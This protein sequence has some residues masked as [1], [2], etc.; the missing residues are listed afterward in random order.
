MKSRAEI[1]VIIAQFPHI[2]PV[3]FQ[4]PNN[5]LASF[6]HAAEHNGEPQKCYNEGLPCLPVPVLSPPAGPSPA[7]G[8]AQG[9][10][11]PFSSFWQLHKFLLPKKNAVLTF[12]SS[13][14]HFEEQE[15]YLC[16]LF[17][18]LSLEVIEERLWTLIKPPLMS[19]K[20]T[21][22]FL[23][24]CYSPL[25]WASWEPA[26][27][28]CNLNEGDQVY[29]VTAFLDLDDTRLTNLCSMLLWQRVENPQENSIAQPF[30]FAFV[31]EACV[32]CN[33]QHTHIYLEVRQHCLHLTAWRNHGWGFRKSAR[34]ICSFYRRFQVFG[35]T[36]SFSQGLGNSLWETVFCIMEGKGLLVC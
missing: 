3:Q 10:R 22:I 12:L 11:T 27:S 4:W 8:G 32:S 33:K 15:N 29:L 28:V 18:W 1:V 17:W 25:D 34:K 14:R 31:T 5:V 30:L 23:L 20:V 9:R 2:L 36:S 13:P 6:T 21:V 26:K 24:Q 19:W 16:G 35:F 7:Q